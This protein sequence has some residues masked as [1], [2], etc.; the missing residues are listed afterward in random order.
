[1]RLLL[2]AVPTRP[3]HPAWLDEIERRMREVDD[4]IVQTVPFGD[5]MA[6]LKAKHEV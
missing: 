2:S 6:A 5:V 4:A 3:L 1:M